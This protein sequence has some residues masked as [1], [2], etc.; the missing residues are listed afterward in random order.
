MSWDGIGKRGGLT[1][2]VSEISE[3][4]CQKSQNCPTAWNSVMVVGLKVNYS[5]GVPYGGKSDDMC[6]HFD[7]VPV[8]YRQDR[9]IYHNK[10]ALYVQ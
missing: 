4:F 9:K 7:T 2:T 1:H 8:R 10:I 3:D 6:F 5:H